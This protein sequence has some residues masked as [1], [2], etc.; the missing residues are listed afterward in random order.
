MV[1][2]LNLLSPETPSS[3]CLPTLPTAEGNPL[4][5]SLWQ[6]ISYLSWWSAMREVAEA[7]RGPIVTSMLYLA[8]GRRF[9]LA[10]WYHFSQWRGQHAFE[11]YGWIVA[12]GAQGFTDVHTPSFSSYCLASYGPPQNRYTSESN[13]SPLGMDTYDWGDV[14]PHRDVLVKAGGE[15]KNSTEKVIK[16][17]SGSVG[18]SADEI[19]I[20]ARGINAARNTQPDPTLSP[21]VES[22]WPHCC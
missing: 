2:A 12:M 21:R 8:P 7:I 5:S 17:P 4:T 11:R 22:G 18:H 16:L 19:D 3:P 14:P 20:S 1:R 10:P 15:V 6:P 13:T 9:A